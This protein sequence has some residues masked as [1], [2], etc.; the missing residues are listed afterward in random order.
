MTK[1]QDLL[2]IKETKEKIYRPTPEVLSKY[3]EILINFALNNGKG[4]KKGETVFIQIPQPALPL[5]NPLQIAVLQAGGHPFFNFLP[6]GFDRSG[7]NK[8][9]FDYAKT[10]QIKYSPKNYL[11]GRIKDADHI[12]NIL[13]SD[14]PLALSKVDSKKII[15]REKSIKYYREAYFSKQDKGQLTWVLA[16]YATEGTAK[17]A[18]LSLK[19]YWEQIIKS[20]F[21]DYENPVAKWKEVLKEQSRVIKA[22][23]KMKIEKVHLQGEG[24]NLEV[25]IGKQ[26]KWLGGRGNNIPSFEIFTS[27]DWRG[28]NGYVEFNEPLYR[29]GKLITGIRLEFKKGKVVKATAKQN[30]D[31]LKEMI[32]AENAD[33][34]GEFSL[35]DRRLSRIDKFMADTLFDENRGGKYGNFHIAV[36]QAYSDGYS[37]DL[38]D[39][40]KSKLEELGLN[41]SPIHTDIISTGKRTVTATL[42]G[43]KTKIIYKDGEFLV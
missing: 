35:T 23:D 28:T 31:L 40:N 11:L 36:G 5:L 39:L 29:Y 14:D 25:Q 10:N 13:S 6:N 15:E 19:E 9:F 20:C 12:V 34:V 42:P 3:A 22:L 2:E 26:R 1:N 30:Q 16:A 43:N 27:P 17:Q 18:G 38:K 7:G 21:L 4:L 41:Q 33:K 37:G 8:A 32:K 24:V